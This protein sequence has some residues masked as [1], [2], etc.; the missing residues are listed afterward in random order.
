MRLLDRARVG[1]GLRLVE[2][3]RRVLDVEGGRLLDLAG[4]RWCDELGC[5]IPV[6]DLLR[7]VDRSRL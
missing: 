1:G 6:T 2:R 5:S 4:G 7:L 3:A